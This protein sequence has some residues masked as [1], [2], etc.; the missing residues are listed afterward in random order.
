MSTRKTQRNIAAC[1]RKRPS[2]RVLV[3]PA[4]TKMVRSAMD[5]IAAR[6]AATVRT[7]IATAMS[8]SNEGKTR[9]SK[10]DYG[11]FEERPRKVHLYQNRNGKTYK[12]GRVEKRYA[13]T[14]CKM[15]NDSPCV[16]TDTDPDEVTCKSCIRKLAKR[17]TPTH[18]GPA[19]AIELSKQMRR[20]AEYVTTPG[21]IEYWRERALAAERQLAAL[22]T[23]QT[24]AGW[25]LENY[26]QEAQ[27]RR[28][29]EIGEMGGGG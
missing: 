6:S 28:D 19:A 16:I 14:L 24:E 26:R 9:M 7:A 25:V 8:A 22:H 1:T 18:H 29:R 17:S 11:P 10:N 5:A 4:T 15:N 23:E 27:R 20:T 13:N 21:T 3:K 12:V 2:M